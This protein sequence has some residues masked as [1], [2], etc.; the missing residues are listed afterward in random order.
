MTTLIALRVR[1]ATALSHQRRANLGPR[2]TVDQWEDV[3]VMQDLDAD[4]LGG[5]TIRHDWYGLD[6]S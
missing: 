5:T 1:A 6:A 2:L 4:R 3:W